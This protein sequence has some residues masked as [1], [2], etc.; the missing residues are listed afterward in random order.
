MPPK[1]KKHQPP[2]R[3]VLL[4]YTGWGPGCDY[5]FNTEMLV[6]SLSPS[7]SLFALAS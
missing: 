2:R 7:G 6:P 5:G 1:Q 4:M 3:P